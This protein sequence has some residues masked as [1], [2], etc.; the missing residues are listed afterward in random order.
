MLR[1]VSLSHARSRRPGPLA[2][3]LLLLLA[4]AGAPPAHAMSGK[5]D[6]SYTGSFPITV[7]DGETL[8][9]AD[10]GSVNSTA[11][12]AI[13]VNQGGM[14]NVTGGSVHGPS[15]A[16]E[17][18]GTVV[19]TGGSISGI[20]GVYMSSGT[21]TM[22]AGSLSGTDT[23]L[24]MGGSGTATISGGTFSGAVFVAG[25]SATITGGVFTGT[26]G[27][28]VLSGGTAMIT[29]GAFH[30]INYGVSASGPVSI[31]GC[32]LQLSD[33]VTNGL[34]TLT[35]TF[36]NGDQISTP[37]F[38]LTASNLVQGSNCD[39]TAPTTTATAT[40][41]GNPYPA[42]AW[43]NQSVTVTLS[44]SDNLGGSG[45]QSIAY[46]LD[47]GKSWTTNSGASVP[48]AITAEGATTL[49]Y[50]AVDNAGNS[51]Q[52]AH[53]FGVMID[54]TAPTLTLTGSPVAAIA[55][56]TAGALVNFSLNASDSGSGLAPN[57]PTATPASG[58]LFPLG[59][60]QV[61]VAATDNAGNTATASFPVTVTYAWS[62]ALQPI[63]ADG[64]SI[65]KAGSTIPVKFA[66]TGASAGITT[67]V[68]SFS[69]ARI[70]DLGS[71]ATVNEDV[72][73]TSPSA[74]N[75]FRYD[76]TSGQYLL[77]WSTKGL[78]SG[79]YQLN[80]DL[81]DGMQRVIIIGLR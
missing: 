44:A 79:L 75:T 52:P 37:T 56:S 71:S 48:V 49:T 6:Y 62:G 2:A 69:Y 36:Q 68:G 34:R 8:T 64:S 35:G 1:S 67:L 45:V 46:S 27:V 14:L 21:V 53:V 65:F 63:N 15:A 33:V 51:E 50:Y 4:L 81:G 54:K 31:V 42:G 80:I 16:I 5:I 41:G 32:G 74:G 40:A 29:G 19:I 3:G 24:T 17:T 61:N 7:G 9:I 72:L 39:S 66:L 11:P 59:A 18:N 25:G 76:P 30:D 10:Q 70:G 13:V 77:N 58:S 47:G 28:D 55:T 57:S 73:Y 60:T 43:T 20:T 22:S 26:Y 78:T 12:R 38:G 23:A